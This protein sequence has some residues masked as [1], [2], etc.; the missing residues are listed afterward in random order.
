MNIEGNI[1]KIQ[2]MQ[3]HMYTWTIKKLQLF[4]SN[5]THTK[6]EEGLFD[7]PLSIKYNDLPLRESELAAP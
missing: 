7:L 3:S 5:K 4:F 6:K 1:T 2:V